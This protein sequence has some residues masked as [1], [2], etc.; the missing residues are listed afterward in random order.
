MESMY[1]DI[2]RFMKEYFPAYSEYG[3]LA[4]T[5]HV[6][7][8]FY[9][10]DLV[11]DDGTV[12][13]REQWYKACL[14]HPAV[15]DK[16]TLE[17]LFVDEKQKEA[18]ALVKTQAIDRKTGKILLELKLYVFYSLKI[19]QNKDIKIA[20]V[21]IFLESDPTKAAKLVQLYAIG[22]QGTKK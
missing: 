10:P 8:K 15:Q 9:A 22:S 6:M 3:Q 1:D 17:H 19:D 2:V 21:R 7:D 4:E 20:R 13:N 5:H 11:F 18:G 16:L 12:T 14:A